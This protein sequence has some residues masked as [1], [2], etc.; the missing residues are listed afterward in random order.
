LPHGRVMK[1]TIPFITFVTLTPTF[2][3]SLSPNQN[4]SPHPTP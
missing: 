1:E 3:V 2:S 4:Q